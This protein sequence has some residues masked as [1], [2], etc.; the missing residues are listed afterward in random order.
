M[1]SCPDSKCLNHV[2]NDICQKKLR[3]LVVQD[4]WEMYEQILMCCNDDLH[5]QERVGGD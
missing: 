2:E 4:T 3:P 5:Y 1:L